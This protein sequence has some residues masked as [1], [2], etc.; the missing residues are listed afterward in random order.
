M[1]GAH[2]DKRQKEGKFI[3]H[4]CLPVKGNHSQNLKSRVQHKKGHCLCSGEKLC[5]ACSPPAV[6]SSAQ[7]AVIVSRTQRVTYLETRLSTENKILRMMITAL[8]ERN[9]HLQMEISRLQHTQ[10]SNK[11]LRKD[12]W[13]QP[14]HNNSRSYTQ[15]A[16]N[17]TK[18]P[19]RDRQLLLRSPRVQWTLNPLP[20]ILLVIVIWGTTKKQL[21]QISW[22]LSPL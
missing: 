11:K 20:C 15:A 10:S 16:T 9:D 17:G 6:E 21:P 13:S 4:S 5:E 3:C 7:Q 18:R 8:E 1:R 2:R 12:R 14:I 22:S 19:P